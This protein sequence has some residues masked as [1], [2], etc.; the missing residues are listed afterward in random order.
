MPYSTKWITL[1]DENAELTSG[2]ESPGME[3]KVKIP[4]TYR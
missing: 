2:I 4:A 1:S 3:D